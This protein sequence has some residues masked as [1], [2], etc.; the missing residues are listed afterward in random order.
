M[1]LRVVSSILKLQPDLESLIAKMKYK[2][3]E[4]IDGGI[5]NIVFFDFDITK[6]MTLKEYGYQEF[7]DLD[8]K[9]EE[10]IMR[11]DYLEFYI[12]PQVGLRGGFGED[13]PMGYDL[14]TKKPRRISDPHYVPKSKSFAL[15][16]I[17]E[18]FEEVI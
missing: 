16:N 5:T 9:A 7:K 4:D 2:Y 15:F 17:D 3:F 13:D 18:I 6:N 1:Y 11:I 14:I 10:L 12:P 8:I